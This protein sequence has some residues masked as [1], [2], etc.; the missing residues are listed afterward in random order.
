MSEDGEQGEEEPQEGV[1]EGEEEPQEGGEE[2]QVK[3]KKRRRGKARPNPKKFE[4][5]TNVK[6]DR[7]AHTRAMGW[8]LFEGGEEWE[9]VVVRLPGGGGGE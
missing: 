7:W 1:Q 5:G 9:R 4:A 3:K 8:G 2:V 6:W